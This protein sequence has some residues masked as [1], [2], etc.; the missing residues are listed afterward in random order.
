M[1][2]VRLHPDF[3]DFIKALNSA[4]VKYML[5]G[6]YAVIFHGYARNTGDMD[7]WV[8]R[9]A[10]NYEK[11]TQAFHLFGMPVFDMTLE[12]FLDHE[13][14][15]VFSFGI[16]PVSIDVITDLKGLDF[17]SVFPYSVDMKSDGIPVKTINLTNLLKAK[18][19]SGRLKD[20]QDIEHL[21]GKNS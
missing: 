20:L 8:E 14:F 12:K 9:T 11:I 7:I 4:E 5:V 15:D 18:Q 17:T 10:E 13:Q 21:K 6:G 19:A 1:N 2:Q 3:L 16:P